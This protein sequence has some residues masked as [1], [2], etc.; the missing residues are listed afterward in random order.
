M[1]PKCFSLFLWCTMEYN[2]NNYCKTHAKILH[3]IWCH[4]IRGMKIEDNFF[5]VII[6]YFLVLFRVLCNN[7]QCNRYIHKIKKVWQPKIAHFMS[8]KLRSE[9]KRRHVGRKR[10]MNYKLHVII[11]KWR[12]KYDIISFLLQ[13]LFLCNTH[14]VWNAKMKSRDY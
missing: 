13:Q 5:K 1:F 7:R 6:Q 4:Q 11:H 10:Y 9:S 12:V 3:H 14:K 2:G 8:Y